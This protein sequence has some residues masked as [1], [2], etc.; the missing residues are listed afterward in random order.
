MFGS[1]NTKSTPRTRQSSI[2]DRT[3]LNTKPNPTEVNYKPSSE[4]SGSSA[5]KTST[6]KEEF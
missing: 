5:K 6:D 4:K 3:K 2:V 1:N